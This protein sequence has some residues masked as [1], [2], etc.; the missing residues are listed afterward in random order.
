MGQSGTKTVNQKIIETDER[1]AYW[2]AEAN[3]AEERGDHAKA[4]KFYAKSG[5]WRDRYNKLVGNW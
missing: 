1:C 2:L 4:E 3:E 5:F